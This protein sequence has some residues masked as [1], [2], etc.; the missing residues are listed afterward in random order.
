MRLRLESTDVIVDEII[1]SNYADVLSLHEYDI[2]GRIARS[3]LSE[4]L[5]ARRSANGGIKYVIK[6]V[7]LFLSTP[8]PDS[9][10]SLV[11]VKEAAILKALSHQNIIKLHSVMYVR[12]ELNEVFMGK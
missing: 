7:E 12:D 2:I 9:A 6:K 3:S 8:Q 5:L 1:R 11:T 4:I 10:E